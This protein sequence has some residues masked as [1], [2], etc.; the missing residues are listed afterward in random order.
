M[1]FGCQLL[2]NCEFDIN[3]NCFI[4]MLSCCFMLK[5]RARTMLADGT[6]L[7]KDIK[8]RWLTSLPVF[9]YNIIFHLM[10]SLQSVYGTNKNVTNRQYDES[11]ILRIDNNPKILRKTSYEFVH[12]FIFS[13][14]WPKNI[15]EFFLH[16]VTPSRSKKKRTRLFCLK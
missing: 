6:F 11:T 15:F 10:T 16:L 12:N 1:I 3:N 9:T 14:V 4:S 8:L 13:Y 2:L 5:P 7:K